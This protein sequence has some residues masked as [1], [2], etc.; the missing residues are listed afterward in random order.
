MSTN[1]SAYSSALATCLELFQYGAEVGFQFTVLDIGGGF[2]GERD[3]DE[4]FDR[5]ARA[6]REGLSQHF[7]P[8]LYPNLKVIAEPGTLCV[9]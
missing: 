3:S 2:P 8:G 7:S 9:D 6:V 5:M 4:L 1:P